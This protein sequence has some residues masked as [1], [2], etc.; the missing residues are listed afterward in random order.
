VEF[1]YIPYCP[2]VRSV[3]VGVSIAGG[4]IALSVDVVFKMLLSLLVARSALFWDIMQRIVAIPYRANLSVP[5]WRLKMGP[6]GC[7][8]TSVRK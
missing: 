6:V 5:S 3:G 4:C 2:A 8:E 7:T 1:Y